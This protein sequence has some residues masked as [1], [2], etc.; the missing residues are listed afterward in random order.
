MVIQRTRA[1]ANGIDPTNQGTSKWT[2]HI[3]PGSYTIQTLT[4]G[5]HGRSRAQDRHTTGA[6]AWGP[7]KVFW[8]ILFSTI[9]LSSETLLG[10]YTSATLTK[11]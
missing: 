9:R 1:H 5:E 11:S 8:R 10:N 3:T 2:S 4:K 6:T 7:C